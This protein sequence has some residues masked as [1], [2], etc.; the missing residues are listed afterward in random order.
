MFV[1]DLKQYYLEQLGIDCWV[2]R[3][4]TREQELYKL[5]QLVSSC[6]RC[7]LYQTRKQTVFSRGNHEAKL[8]IIG[9]AP[10]ESEDTLGKPFVGKS[11]ELLDRMLGCIGFR[12]QDV[13]IANLLKCR[14]PNA[15]DPESCEIEACGAYLR[16]QIQLV[17]PKLI[18]AVG[19]FAGEFLF[20]VH[21][22]LE[23]LRSML[24]HYDNR[25]FIV[26]YHPDFLL[27]NPQHKKEA[28][29]DLLFVNNTLKSFL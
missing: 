4:P 28:Y 24:H 16:Q 13:Y 20:G 18:L 7:N 22:S 1:N 5:A 26:T 2:K 12:E 8:M 11:G 6:A 25:P 14:P 17:S 10:G 21:A 27:R 19:Q 29:H 23:K 9:E 15:R 3:E